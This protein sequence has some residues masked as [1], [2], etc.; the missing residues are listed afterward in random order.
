[1]KPGKLE[2]QPIPLIV[3]TLWF[4]ICSSTSAFSTAASTPKSPHPGHQS[5][6]TF[7]LKSAIV[8]CHSEARAVAIFLSPRTGISFLHRL[9]NSHYSSHQNL[10]H[11]NRKLSLAIQLL[12]DRLDD[13]MR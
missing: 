7:P 6:S 10:V 9:A 1:M 4:G 5:G 2:E 3:T 12:Y 8:T 13:V 11:R